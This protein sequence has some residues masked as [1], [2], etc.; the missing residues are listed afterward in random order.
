MN[1]YLARLPILVDKHKPKNKCPGN[2]FRK[3]HIY[4]QGGKG[5]KKDAVKVSYMEEIALQ[6]F[7][8]TGK[9][10][11]LRSESSLITET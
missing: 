6:I 4:T 7:S 8:S 11:T 1:C 2:F 3:L 10:A 9:S 5:A